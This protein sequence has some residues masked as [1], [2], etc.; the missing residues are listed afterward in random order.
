MK[1]YQS[2]LI[3]SLCLVILAA[4][5]TQPAP[6]LTPL[7]RPTDALP[8]ITAV[9][10]P[11]VMPTRPP[12]PTAV[13]SPTP[14]PIP[15]ADPSPTAFQNIITAEQIT[16]IAWQWTEVSQ[17]ALLAPILVPE[18]GKYTVIFTANG[19]VSVQADCNSAGGTY[20]LENNLL[21][22]NLG[23]QTLSFCG[24][25]SLDQ[26]F[27]SLLGKSREVSLDDGRLLLA[28]GEEAGEM[29]FRSGGAAAAVAASAES[30]PLVG[31]TWQWVRF[32]NPATGPEAIAE[33]NL[34][35]LQLRADGRVS[36]QADCSTGSGVYLLDGGGI[37]ITIEEVSQTDCAANSR[38]D[39]FLRYLEAAAI[40]FM[41]ETDLLFDLPMD[42]G[43]MR[44]QAV[45]AETISNGQPL[46][47]EN[48]P[49][50]N[51]RTVQLDVLDVA[52]SFSWQVQPALLAP[53]T[54][55]SHAMPAH[56][57][58]TFD[59]EDAQ[60]V[61]ANNG[62]RL[63]IFPIETYQTLAGSLVTNQVDRLVELLA[64]A[65][66]RDGSPGGPLPFLPL[67]LGMMDRWVQF[68]DLAFSQGLGVRYLA[69]SPDRQAIGPWTNETTAYYY[70][71]LSQDG[72]YYISLI[73]PVRTEALPDT[74]EEAEERVK[75]QSTNPATYPAYLQ[76]TQALLNA[77]SPS[78][79]YPD[80]PRLDRMIAS[81]VL[82]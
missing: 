49:T 2:L 9:P 22:I 24:E 46:T 30:T 55:G 82:K 20:I 74:F 8:T 19:L 31:K 75:D 61:L 50:L 73:W 11:T 64:A 39:D 58:V 29:G 5:R 17:N 45:S 63:Y 36:I 70:Q 43:T 66:G 71:G 67:P 1:K 80:L 3:L 25:Q 33:P 6:T 76:E 42:T 77:L 53:S 79:Y 56:I 81:L 51:A 23:A 44:F 62:R 48:S 34:Y 40:W 52:S 10:L 15:T 18:P 72:K 69:D 41:D 47:K 12:A 60:E 4:C 57:L 21:T 7:P 38:A 26:Q 78:A 54:P 32:I 27:L 68:T 14:R 65:D 16:D 28:L 35:T 59:G 37:T 13:P